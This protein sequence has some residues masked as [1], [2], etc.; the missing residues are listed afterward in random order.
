M[1]GKA[2]FKLTL[3]GAE[4]LAAKLRPEG[5]YGRPVASLIEE[6]TK[7]ALQLATKRAP[8]RGGALAGS[9]RKDLRGTVVDP[10]GVVSFA[11]ANKGFRYGQAL[12]ASARYHYAAAG[13]SAGGKRRA[14]GKPTKKWFTGIP[15]LVRGQLARLLKRA[16]AE[17][18]AQWAR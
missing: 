7:L 15:G 3:E 16:D 8:V 9:L 5:L 1:A 4:T 6:A 12:N 2:T 11:V 10:Y 14:G 17:I 13:T 18:E